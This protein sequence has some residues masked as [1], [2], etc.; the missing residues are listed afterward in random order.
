[1]WEAVRPHTLPD[2]KHYT[3]TS[4]AELQSKGV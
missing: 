1:M 4:I 3:M 2:D